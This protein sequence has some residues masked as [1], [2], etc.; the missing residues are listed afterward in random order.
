VTRQPRCWGLVDKMLHHPIATVATAAIAARTVVAAVLNVTD[1]WSLAPD[2]GQYLAVAEAAADGRLQTFWLGY[3]ESLYWSTWTY[4]A[5]LAFLFDVF[6][7][8][9]ALG[10]GISVIFGVATAAITTMIALRLVRRPYAVGAGL[11]VALTPSQI[12][13]S[14]VALRESTV[15]VVLALAGFLLAMATSED[16]GYRVVLKTVGLGVCY[17]ALVSLRSQT[18]FL[19][20]WCAAAAIVIGP[21]KRA[22]RFGVAMVLLL[23]MPVSVGRSIGELEFL[24]QALGGL[25]TV[26]TYMSMGAESAIVEPTRYFEDSEDSEDSPP[27]TMKAPSSMSGEVVLPTVP[28]SSLGVMET[29]T[30]GGNPQVLDREVSTSSDG[31]KFVIDF[32]GHAVLVQNDLS[33]S[34]RAF[35]NGLVAVAVRPVPWEEMGSGKR[36]AA[37]VESLLW[38]PAFVLAAVGAWVRRRNLAIVVFPALLAAA[39]MV[40]GAVTHG[41]LGTAFRHRGQVLWALAILAVAAVQ[42]I[43]DRS[44]AGPLNRRSGTP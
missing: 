36:L 38:F 21:G 19:F 14:S 18:A 44:T 27:P 5:P 22:V 1:T 11:I 31:Q 4:S 43:R 34:V 25:G 33:A 7:P 39:V 35:P 8:Y 30:S 32:E 26:R 15:W 9:R 28:V 12:L 20:L 23:L 13:W 2:G 29:D 16:V 41:N 40:S 6:G 10:Q 42:H 17:A 37:G 3:G 24:N